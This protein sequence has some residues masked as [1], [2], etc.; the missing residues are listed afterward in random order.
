MVLS[1][2]NDRTAVSFWISISIFMI[3]LRVFSPFSFYVSFI[4]SHTHTQS[5]KI[6]LGTSIWFWNIGSKTCTKMTSYKNTPLFLCVAPNSSSNLPSTSEKLW[7][8]LSRKKSRGRF[9]LP[10][11]HLHPP[12]PQRGKSMAEQT[13]DDSLGTWTTRTVSSAGTFSNSLNFWQRMWK[14]T[15]PAWRA[16]S[17]PT[18]H[19]HLPPRV[20]SRASR[21]VNDNLQTSTCG[22]V[23]AKR[24]MSVAGHHVIMACLSQT[25]SWRTKTSEERES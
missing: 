10:T 11:P 22:D 23:A 19:H 25:S 8:Q 14:L 13:N 17:W 1:W 6:F 2:K 20:Q 24:N 12:P 21:L 18:E 5:Q 15:G 7:K 16:Q 4:H 3:F 9:P